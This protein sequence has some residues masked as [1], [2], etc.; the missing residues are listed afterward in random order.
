MSYD[1]LLPFVRGCADGAIQDHAMLLNTDAPRQERYLFGSFTCRIPRLVLMIELASKDCYVYGSSTL[2]RVCLDQ[3]VH[4]FLT[5]SHP[6]HDIE[7]WSW[8][9]NCDQGL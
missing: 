7:S 6:L 5:G 3:T 8:S 2:G 9:A 4:T 1:V